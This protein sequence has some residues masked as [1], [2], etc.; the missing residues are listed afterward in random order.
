MNRVVKNVKMNAWSRATKIS[1]KVIAT[2]PRTTGTATPRP[3]A[4]PLAAGEDEAQQHRKQH[5][6]GDHVGAETHDQGEDP[7]D[8]SDHLDGDQQPGQPEGAGIEVGEELP[9]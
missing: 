9:A 6:P 8:Q 3:L 4:M 2:L 7:R 1:S 5:M